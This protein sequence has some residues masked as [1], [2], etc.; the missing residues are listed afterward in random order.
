MELVMLFLTIAAVLLM[1]IGLTNIRDKDPQT[2]TK[3]MFV[4][5]FML[6]MLD[7]WCYLAY[8]GIFFN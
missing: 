5:G 1:G 7:I 3:G 4:A 2:S 6:L 8:N